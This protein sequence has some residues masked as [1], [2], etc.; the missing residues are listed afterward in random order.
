MDKIDTRKLSTERQQ[1]NRDQAIRLHL[2]GM[3][4]KDIAH[5]VGIHTSTLGTWIALYNKGGAEALKIGQRGRREGD[6]KTLTESQEVKLKE[7]IQ[8][9]FPDQM[10]LPFALWSSTAIRSL[11][12]DLWGIDMPQRTISAYMQRW[13]YT[14][15]V[16]AKRAYERSDKATQE[17]LDQTYPY[18][19]KRA[20][21]FGAE[22]LWGDETGISNQCQH[23]RGYAPKGQTPLLKTQSKRLRTNLISAVNNRGKLRF[24]MYRETMTSTVLIRFMKRLIKDTSSLKVFLILDNLKVH[25]SKLVKEWL[26]ENK[27]SIEVYFLP[28]YSPDMNPDEYLNCDLKQGIRAS[29]PAR[30]QKQLEKKVLGHMRKIQALPKRVMSYFLHPCI[31]YAAS[32]I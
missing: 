25:H 11:I 9:K 15:Q 1:H 20:E 27:A 8:G 26:E 5:I 17:W 10:K 23:T 30:N 28:P 22:I 24:M 18:I 13:G 3:S 29:S 21:I 2:E 32:G 19:K 16:P 14:P 7:I 12:L 6:G 31:Q 4:R